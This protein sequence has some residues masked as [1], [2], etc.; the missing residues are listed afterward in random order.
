MFFCSTLLSGQSA[1]SLTAAPT[2]VFGFKDFRSQ[3]KIDSDFLKIPD[4][5]LAGEHLKTLTAAPHIASSKEDY[6]TAEYVAAKFKAAG[7][8]TSIVPYRVWMNLPKTIVV[9][10]FGADGK[11]IMKGPSP[12]HV[13][14]D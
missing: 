6:A 8:D 7:L 5:K 13:S 4:A 14:S 12:E 1:P 11:Q 3:A 9:E 2:G 10:A